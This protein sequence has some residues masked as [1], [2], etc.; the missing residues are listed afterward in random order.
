M[1]SL[2]VTQCATK[3]QVIF[4]VYKQTNVFIK[5]HNMYLIWYVV[6]YDFRNAIVISVNNNLAK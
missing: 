5:Y 3:F 4:L 2:Y 6:Q 1:F